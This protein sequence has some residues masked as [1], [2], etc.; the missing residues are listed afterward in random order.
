MSHYLFPHQYITRLGIEKFKIQITNHL[1]EL[2]GENLAILFLCSI[3][4][5]MYMYMI[6]ISSKILHI[7]LQ[8]Q[9]LFIRYL[10]VKPNNGNCVYTYFALRAKCLSFGHTHLSMAPE[11]VISPIDVPRTAIHSPLH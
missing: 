2:I 3:Y 5:L 10:V 9:S 11:P 6:C 7:H 4:L 8:F 1:L